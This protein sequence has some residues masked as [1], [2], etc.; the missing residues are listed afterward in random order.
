MRLK[1]PQTRFTAP[2]F[3]ELDVDHQLLLSLNEET[4]AAK[5]KEKAVVDLDFGD[6]DIDDNCYIYHQEK[7]ST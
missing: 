2:P 1:R 5:P 6:F 7:G 4:E 3:R